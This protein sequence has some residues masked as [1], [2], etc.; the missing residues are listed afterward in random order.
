MCHR[1]LELGCLDKPDHEEEA[2][3][4]LESYEDLAQGDAD[5]GKES[6]IY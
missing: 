5:K 1:L 4:F 3:Q 6:D 2:W